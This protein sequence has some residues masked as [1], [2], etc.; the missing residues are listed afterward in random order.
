MFVLVIPVRDYTIQSNRV[1]PYDLKAPN[2]LLYIVLY[3]L[4]TIYSRVYIIYYRLYSVHMAYLDTIARPPKGGNQVLH[5]WLRAMWE[6][7]L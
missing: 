7:R 2:N 4:Y 3:K 5:T 1:R 6:P